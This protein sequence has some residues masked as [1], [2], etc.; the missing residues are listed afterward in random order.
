MSGFATEHR[1]M[2]KEMFA[3]YRVHMSEVSRAYDELPGEVFKDGAV[4]G[5]HKRLMAL[6]G[7][8]VRGCDGCIYL[9]TEQALE[10]GA[11]VDEVLET[12][13]VAI[14]LGGT[15]AAAET[16]KVVAYLREQGR[17]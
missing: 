7:A 6:C 13:A 9:Q 16:T 4:S 12:C 14:S 10:L 2:T 17:L 15:M 1:E 11:E 5:K 8:L 3:L